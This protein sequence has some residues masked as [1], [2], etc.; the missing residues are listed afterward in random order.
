MYLEGSVRSLMEVL[1]RHISGVTLKKTTE[2]LSGWSDQH[3]IQKFF[4]YKSIECALLLR[5]IDGFVMVGVFS[6]WTKETVH[7]VRHYLVLLPFDDALEVHVTAFT[8]LD[9]GMGCTKLVSTPHSSLPSAFR[10]QYTSIII[11]LKISDTYV[12]W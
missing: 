11:W 12:G 1:L 6:L 3:S 5:Q 7:T 4:K 10:A 8:R 9:S 2:D